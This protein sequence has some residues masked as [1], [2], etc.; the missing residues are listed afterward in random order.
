MLPGRPCLTPAQEKEVLEKV[1]EIEADLPFYVAIINKS[2]VYKRG[3][4]T[5]ILVSSAKSIFYCFLSDP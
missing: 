3:S 2:N 5:P 1:K 4:P